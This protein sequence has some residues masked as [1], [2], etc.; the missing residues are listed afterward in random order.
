MVPNTPPNQHVP[1]PRAAPDASDVV[2]D[3]SGQAGLTNEQRL[4][5]ERRKLREREQQLIASFGDRDITSDRADQAQLLEGVHELQWVRDRIAEI[6]QLLADLRQPR[7]QARSG[8]IGIGATVDLE[9][10][11]GSH[12]AVWLGSPGL[13]H[14]DEAVVTPSSPLGQAL[15]GHRAGDSVDY[16]TPAGPQR[17]R[18]LAVRSAQLGSEAATSR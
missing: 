15:L 10:Q 8:R 18:V 13:A 5:A 12:E 6:S 3:A 17:V 9:Y 4:E 14:V 16:T 11:D 1:E 7:G 2:K